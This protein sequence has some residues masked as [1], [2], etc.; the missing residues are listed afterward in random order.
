[1]VKKF[2]T[3]AFFVLTQYRRATDRQTDG[4]VAIAKE[5]CCGPRRHY[6]VGGEFHVIELAIKITRRQYVMY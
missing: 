2:M 3:I 1:M 5:K 4:H 6:C